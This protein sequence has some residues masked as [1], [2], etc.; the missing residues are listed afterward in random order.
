MAYLSSNERKERPRERHE[1][2]LCVWVHP[3]TLAL[4]NGQR[5]N[6]CAVFNLLSSRGQRCI[7][8]LAVTH[9]LIYNAANP[10]VVPGSIRSSSA[11]FFLS[12]P[13]HP[14]TLTHTHVQYL[15]SM[16]VPAQVL[17]EAVEADVVGLTLRPCRA[18]GQAV[19]VLLHLLH[20]QHNTHTHTKDLTLLCEVKTDKIRGNRV[21]EL[22]HGRLSR[23]V[24]IGHCFMLNGCRV[25]K[26]SRPEAHSWK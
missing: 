22:T 15:G 14:P 8:I 9:V 20:L 17:R 13:P 24:V 12:P 2:C 25:E 6:M 21:E 18:E 3:E 11:F 10:W 4:Q 5:W 16:S 23:L 1:W 26:C 7:F 19:T